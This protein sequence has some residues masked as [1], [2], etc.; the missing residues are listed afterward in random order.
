MTWSSPQPHPDEL[1][2]SLEL[3]LA[4]RRSPNLVSS[5]QS[6]QGLIRQ[7][8]RAAIDVSP[9]GI[10]RRW[11]LVVA[12]PQPH[13]ERLQTLASLA[14]DQMDA[15]GFF[16]LVRTSNKFSADVRGRLDHIEKLVERALKELGDSELDARLVQERTWQLLS[17]LVV[18]MPRLES[19]HESDW[20]AVENSLTK[21]AQSSDLAGASRLRDR[22]VAMAGE[23]S[24]K[25]ARVDLT[26]LR[27]DT[28]G[29]LDG[30]ERRHQKGWLALGHL[31]EAALTSVRNEIATIDGDRRA[32]LDRSDAVKELV[33][34][35]EDA[36]AVLISGDS[37]VGKSALTLLS[38][39]SAAKVDPESTQT[40]CIN[41]R[42]IPKETV[43]FES[44]LDRPL[45]VLLCE[46]SAPRRMLI[47]DGADAATEGMGRRLPAPG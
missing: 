13:A 29:M 42:Q 19:P 22:L 15:S 37:G 36:E 44:I 9:D 39:T 26:L 6:T 21:V 20:S 33:A 4:V 16:K 5:D 31:H 12:G 8:V 30:S 28:H 35:A 18:I 7:F 32:S 17:G 34:T 47:I 45:T 2:P 46:L 43:T 41:L 11:G 3:A 25:A 27:R 1:E 40:L 10:E 38:L 24:P 23:Y 14:A